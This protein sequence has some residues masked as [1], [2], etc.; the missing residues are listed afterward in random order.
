LITHLGVGI[1]DVL[2][3][4]EVRTAAEAAGLGVRLPR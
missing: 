4:E 2:F 3:A 1:A